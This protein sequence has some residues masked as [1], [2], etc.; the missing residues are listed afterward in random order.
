MASQINKNN[1]FSFIVLPLVVFFFYP[2]LQDPTGIPKLIGLILGTFT[3]YILNQRY[4][5]IVR[6]IQFLPW[7]IIFSYILIQS[8]KNNNIE[9][10]ILGTYTRNGGLIT[11][12]SFAVI[13]TIISNF[14]I[15]QVSQ[16]LKSFKLTY[17]GLLLY[18]IFQEF[19]LL[20][21][22]QTNNY[23]G[24]ISLTLSNPNFASAYL[25]IA[26][27]IMP[28]LISKTNY[29]RYIDVMSL[30]LGY[31]LLFRTESIQGFMIVLVNFVIYLIYF[32]DKLLNMG[33]KWKGIFPFFAFSILIIIILNL[34]NIA[35]WLYINGSIRQRFNY[36][37]LVVRIF[38]DN[39]IFGVGLDN[40]VNKVNFYRDIEFLRQEGTFTVIDRAHN[41]FL[42][43]FVN[44]GILVGSLWLVFIFLVSKKSIKLMSFNQLDLPKSSKFAIIGI[45]FGYVLQSLVSAD[46]LSLTLLAFIS[47]GFIISIL[48][49]ENF[50]KSSYMKSNSRVKAGFFSVLFSIF[51]L[52][53]VY[54]ARIEQWVY[55]VVQNSNYTYIDRIYNTK[56]IA[57]RALENVAVK[58]SN[59][60]QYELANK[61][62]DKL[63]QFNRNSHQAFFMKAVYYES[64]GDLIKAKELMLS[65]LSN[66]KLNSVYLLSMALYENKLGNKDDAS[67]YLRKTIE[68]DPTQQGID[69][70]KNEILDDKFLK[71]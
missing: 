45:W 26:L 31:Y 3:L 19:D 30:F 52:Y 13:F 42:D 51:L 54:I 15:N 5:Q 57:P 49:P 28:F 40:L 67:E 60:K 50:E 70:V 4:L 21:F 47:G 37:E 48:N 17:Y 29:V 9:E 22:K 41:V 34:A 35:N 44:G 32:K 20:P 59:D 16:F 55:Q 38:K 65:A 43:H 62:G 63:L 1:K 8:F 33:K 23:G 58:I 7:L 24:S 53:G 64:K 25:G 27:S 36:W 61:F 66:D 10:F 68:V 14:G 71:E 12:V 18:G 2:D 69:Y 56:S 39:L 46:H 6:P 11:L